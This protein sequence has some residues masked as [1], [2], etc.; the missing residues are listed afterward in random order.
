M[1]DYQWQRRHQAHSPRI[2]NPVDVKEPS[3]RPS[4]IDRLRRLGVVSGTN[5]PVR[6]PALPTGNGPS[7]R[8][9]RSWGRSGVGPEEHGES[10]LA[11]SVHGAG[12]GGGTTNSLRSRLGHGMICGS[13]GF[14]GQE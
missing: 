11:E 8:R 1:A 7:A 6:G 9:G 14:G 2:A 10:A 3:L 12:S 13:A 5:P 4:Q